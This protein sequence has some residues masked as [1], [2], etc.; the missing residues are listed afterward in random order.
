MGSFTTTLGWGF[1]P[2]KIKKS[3]N[4]NLV[5]HGRE[6]IEFGK[7]TKEVLAEIIKMAM[8]ERTVS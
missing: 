7:T 3:R 8:T 4:H 1:G 2:F 6:G 5:L